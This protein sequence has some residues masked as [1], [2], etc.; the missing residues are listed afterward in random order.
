M[1]WLE[2]SLKQIEYWKPDMTYLCE[3]CWDPKFPAR[4]T[5]G[6]REYLE[7]WQ[8]G[9]ENVWI[10]DNLRVSDY[11]QNQANQCRLVTQSSGAEPGDWMMYMACD[12]YMFKSHIEMYKDM[13]KSNSFDY[14]IFEIR[15][16][17]DTTT[18]YFSKWAEMALNLPWRLVKDFNWEPICHLAKDGVLYNNHKKVRGKKIDVKGF[19]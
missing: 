18:K 16:F 6:T 5:D 15:N 2:A 17:W 9:R 13:M 8:K 14:P 12:F 4:S 7:K 11:R 10:Q 19:H 1:D 3:G